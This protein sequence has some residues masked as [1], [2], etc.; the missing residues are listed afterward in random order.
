[1]HLHNWNFLLK[2]KR[3]ITLC[4]TYSCDSE[5]NVFLTWYDNC[6]NFFATTGCFSICLPR[7]MR[8]S[9]LHIPFRHR[10]VLLTNTDS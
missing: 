1:M 5:S 3:A 8:S 10:G 9:C 2:K 4:L 7:S 6:V